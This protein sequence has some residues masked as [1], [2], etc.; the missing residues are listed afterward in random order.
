LGLPDG[1]YMGCL[2]CGN[3]AADLK[4]PCTFVFDY[5]KT[6]QP[7]RSNMSAEFSR[8]A[9]AIALVETMVKE[10]LDKS[11]PTVEFEVYVVWFCYILGGWKALVSTSLPDGRYYEVT[12]NKEKKET[13]V[14]MYVKVDNICFP[15]SETK[16]A[17]QG[18]AY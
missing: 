13:Y 5:S 14:D 9:K 1:F 17:E 16:V 15:D 11:D 10:R 18:Y 6:N 3:N 7:R 12:Y 8:Q 2:N 4:D